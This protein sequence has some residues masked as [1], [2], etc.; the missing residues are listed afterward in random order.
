MT[1][2]ITRAIEQATSVLDHQY[3]NDIAPFDE[4]NPSAEN[5]AAWL[6]QRLSDALND[7]RA[8]VRAV[9]L[10]E[11]NDFSVRYSEGS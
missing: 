1:F 10:W 11:T 7:D 6:Y 9:V 3:I 5:I 2:D 8:S 4:I